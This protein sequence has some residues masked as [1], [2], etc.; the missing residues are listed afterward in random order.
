MKRYKAIIVICSFLWMPILGNAQ[1]IP[2]FSQ[3]IK[4]LEFVNPGYNAS[5][6][7]SSVVM[8]HR[9]QWTGFEGAPKSY[10]LNL[11]LPINKWHA[12]AGI[13]L[14]NETTGL[15]TQTNADFQANVDVQI[16]HISY[17]TFGLSAGLEMKRYDLDRADYMDSGSPITGDYNGNNFHTAVGVNYF[18]NAL[19][20]GASMHYSQLSYQADFGDHM[21]WYAN[22]SY[23]VDIH[24]DWML[25]PALMYRQ[26]ADWNDF[27]LSASVLYKDLFWGG[28]SYRLKNAVILF[29]DVKVAEFLRVGYSYDFSANGIAN[30]NNDTHEFRIELI[31]P[32][33][34][35]D[36]ERVAIH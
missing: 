21:A 26:F 30:M 36:F 31:I 34:K 29:A 14:L 35:R 11:H 27:E 22:A 18:T 17:L 3:L 8:L 7:V 9:N 5:K 13:N 32:R 28:I 16:G 12:G 4:T 24:P 33:K 2:Q 6:D 20:L 10:A 19:H 1:Y 23:L 15:V 25:K